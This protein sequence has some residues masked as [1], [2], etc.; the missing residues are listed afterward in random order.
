MRVRVLKCDWN[1]IVDCCYFDA[2]RL[3]FRISI[4]RSQWLE[5]Q[6]CWCPFWIVRSG[7][8]AS[9]RCQE[10]NAPWRARAA[11]GSNSLAC[12]DDS[13]WR[14]EAVARHQLV[15][16]AHIAALPPSHWPRATSFHSR[17]S[18]ITPIV[19]AGE[20]LWIDCALNTQRCPPVYT[21][22]CVNTIRG[23]LVRLLLVCSRSS[24]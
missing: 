14:R 18:R 1:E 11:R 22:Y 5:A 21:I 23:L 2:V 12:R 3:R 19:A 15:I 9:S 8:I 10:N 16:A 4:P 24:V 20:L 6:G 13:P 17:S 7:G